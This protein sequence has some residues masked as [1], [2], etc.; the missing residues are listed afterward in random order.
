MLVVGD[1]VVF[2]DVFTDPPQAVSKAV[3][4]GGVRRNI[5]GLTGPPDNYESLAKRSTNAWV[6]GCTLGGI[7][8]CMTENAA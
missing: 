3:L 2:P 5:Y 7:R 6:L 8:S 4:D 1:L